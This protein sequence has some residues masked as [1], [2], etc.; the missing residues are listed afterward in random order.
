VI[1]SGRTNASLV[2]LPRI[3]PGAKSIRGKALLDWLKA[4]GAEPIPRKERER[5][6]KAGL[7]GMPDE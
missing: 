2:P 4:Q 7:L 3:R 1:S 6:R 5:L